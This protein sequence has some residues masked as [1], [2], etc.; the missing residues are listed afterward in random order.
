MPANQDDN[1][2]WKKI[3]EPKTLDMEEVVE[4]YS[5][6]PPPA[7]SN[8]EEKVVKIVGPQ[9]RSFFNPDEQRNISIGMSKLPRPDVIKEAAITYNL[10]AMS[11]E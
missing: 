2:I 9:K 5:T 6:A 11:N 7:K 3:E 10:K 1:I 8:D 4:L